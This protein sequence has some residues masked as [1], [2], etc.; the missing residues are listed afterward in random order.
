MNKTDTD[1]TQTTSPVRFLF[2]IKIFAMNY[3]L[4]FLFSPDVYDSSWWKESM[5]RVSEKL[6]RMGFLLCV[7]AVPAFN[8]KKKGAISLKPAE[9]INLSYSPSIRYDPDNMMCWMLIPDTMSTAN[10]M[11]YFKYVIKTEVNPLARHGV[12]GPDGDVKIKLF[13]VSLDL[14]E[15]K[16]F[17]NQVCL[18]PCMYPNP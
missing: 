15:K 2:F 17:Y 1:I 12:P 10:E 9:L 18:C 11:K 3:V 8:A 13:G 7:D 4:T 6:E 14:K 16:K 5:G